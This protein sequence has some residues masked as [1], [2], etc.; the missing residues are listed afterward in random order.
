MVGCVRA[1]S[2]QIRSSVG[3]EDFLYALFGVFNIFRPGVAGG[4]GVRNEGKYM[5]IREVE[6]EWWARRG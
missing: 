3:N 4:K 6:I 5:K 2:A 1:R